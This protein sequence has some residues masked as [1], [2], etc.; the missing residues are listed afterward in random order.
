MP[1]DLL[2]FQNSNLASLP[3]SRL[4]TGHPWEPNCLYPAF[5]FK[6]DKWVSLAG[7]IIKT[8]NWTTLAS[9]WLLF[10]FFFFKTDNWATLTGSTFKGD[11]LIKR[12]KERNRFEK[13]MYNT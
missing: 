1:H 10:W 2:C 11:E 8:D 12:M 6:N 7:P 5:F 9:K 4:I 13:Y 3:G